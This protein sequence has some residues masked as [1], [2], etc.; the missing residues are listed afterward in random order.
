MCAPWFSGYLGLEQ[1]ESVKFPRQ[2]IVFLCGALFQINLEVWLLVTFLSEVVELGA[3]MEFSGTEHM[4]G[5]LFD[6]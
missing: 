2:P 5:L 3:G 4:Q 6:L 1:V